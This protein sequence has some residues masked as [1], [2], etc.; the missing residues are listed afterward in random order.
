MRPIAERLAAVRGSKGVLLGKEG[1]AAATLDA[2]LAGPDAVPLSVADKVLSDLKSMA[3]TNHPDLRNAGQGIAAKAVSELHKMVTEAAERAG[4]EAVRALDEGRTATKAKYEA[5]RVL[6]QLEGAQ[7]TKSPTTAFRGAVAGGDIRAP[8]LADVIK[9]AP[10]TKPLIGRAVLDGLIDSPTAGAAK[11]WS[12]WQKIGPETKALLYTAEHVK[13]LDAFFKLR[14]MMADN[15]NPSGTAHTLLSVA[16]GGHLLSNPVSGLA[17]QVGG[18]ALSSLLRS[19]AGVRLLT[20][21]LRIPVKNQ[22]ASAAWAADFAA[23]TNPSGR[24]PHPAGAPAR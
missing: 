16:Q 18:A 15:P 4:P 17:V 11:T 20:R 2:M 23:A 7:R 14:K 12:D 24:P 22:A 21:G 5:A 1:Q 19:K 9:Q 3:R 8:H 6:K 10:E 13:D